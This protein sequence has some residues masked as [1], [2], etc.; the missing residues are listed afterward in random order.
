MTGQSVGLA[1]KP[2]HSQEEGETKQKRG[3]NKKKSRAKKRDDCAYETFFV[4]D[5]TMNA[6]V[7]FGMVRKGH[8]IVKL[9]TR[10]HCSSKK[11]LL[12]MKNS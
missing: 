3:R 2:A 12:G 8:F 11:P 9:M 7:R 10:W 4:V 6:S 5:A 1:S